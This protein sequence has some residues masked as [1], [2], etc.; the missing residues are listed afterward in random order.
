MA[1]AARKPHPLA[2]GVGHSQN[3]PAL[4]P[5]ETP[6]HIPPVEV[7]LIQEQATLIQEDI[8]D[9]T[10]QVIQEP[11]VTPTSILVEPIL[12][13]IQTRTLQVAIQLQVDTQLVGDTLTK[14]QGEGITQ[15][16][17]HL[18]EA[19]QQ[20]VAI[21]TNIQAELAPT[22]E[23]IRTITPVQ[24]ATQLQEATRPEE[25]TQQPVD[26]LTKG[27]LISTQQLVVTQSEGEIQDRAGAS[28]LSI[29]GVTLVE[30][31]VVTPTGTQ[32]IRSSVPGMVEEV[33]DMVVMGWEA[34]LS[35]VLCKIWDTSPSLQVLPKKPWWQQALVLWPGWPLDMD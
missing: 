15:I 2:T 24:E 1:A 20:Q 13:V 33:M 12:E 8:P 14:T 5:T 29:Q 17:I 35:L 4:N 6:I 3:H 21:L 22:K 32:I 23:D 34:L 27:P 10:L 11:V 25:A 28:L 18:L 26:I 19:T 9:K 30:R 7:T 31:L 16:S